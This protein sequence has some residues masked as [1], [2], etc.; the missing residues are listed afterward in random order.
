MDELDAIDTSDSNNV[1][2]NRYGHIDDV[3]VTEATDRS[4]P[5]TVANAATMTTEKY[6]EIWQDTNPLLVKNCMDRKKVS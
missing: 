2:S 1:P 6:Q 3:K 4:L 5:T